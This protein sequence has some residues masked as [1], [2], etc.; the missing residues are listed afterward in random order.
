MAITYAWRLDANKYA[1]IINPDTGEYGF[2]SKTP[3]TGNRLE[4]IANTAKELFECEP[5]Y[6]NGKLVECTKEDKEEKRSLYIEAFNA[7]QT[8]VLKELGSFDMLSPDVYFDVDSTNCSD[9]R[10]VG[11]KGFNFLGTA[12]SWDFKNPHWN[13]QGDI[14]KSGTFLVYGVY[15]NDQVDNNGNVDTNATPE[16]FFV[17]KNGVN[18]TDANGNLGTAELEDRIKA[19]EDRSIDADNEM[20]RDISELKKK[21]N[22]LSSISGGDLSQLIN[23]VTSL[24]T[25]VITLQNELNDLKNKVAA[26]QQWID[27]NEEGGSGDDVNNPTEGVGFDGSEA[28]NN[29]TYYL[30]VADSNNKLFKTSVK[31]PEDITVTYQNGKLYAAKGFYQID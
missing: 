5:Y 8:K 15:M 6:Q 4:I 24:S 30:I 22:A 29:E 16:S 27:S 10:G 25:Q 20:S 7:M 1:Y 11:I 2:A 26:H 14:K 21:V 13:S 28:N 31:K 23:T 19:E 9:L 3:V 12:D 17:V 18:G